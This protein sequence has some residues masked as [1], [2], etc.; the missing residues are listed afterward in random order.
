MSETMR[1]SNPR[2]T[3]LLISS[4]C[5]SLSNPSDWCFPPWSSISLLWIEFSSVQ[6]WLNS[7]PIK[8]TMGITRSHAES[9]WDK[10]QRRLQLG[11]VPSSTIVAGTQL[12][13]SHSLRWPHLCSPVLPRTQ[14]AA[15]SAGQIQ[16]R[17]CGQLNDSSTQNM[18]FCGSVLCSMDAC[19]EIH[20]D[21][22]IF[23]SVVYFSKVNKPNTY[24]GLA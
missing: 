12:G 24:I 1:L 6:H 18:R 17:G 4:H 9:S 22:L 21:N 10:N 11:N 16:A 14:K 7:L 19:T 2:S 13:M 20:G 8:A 15:L 5:Q 23:G 3:T